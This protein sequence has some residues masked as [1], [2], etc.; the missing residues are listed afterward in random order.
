MIKTS[1][2]V[3]ASQHE[4]YGMFTVLSILLAPVAFILGIV[5]L[6]KKDILDRKLGEHL[7]AFSVFVM[8]VSSIL[9]YLFVPHQIITTVPT[10]TTPAVMSEPSLPAWDFEGVY[11]RIIEGQT[12]AEVSTIAGRS[13]DSCGESAIGG[14]VYES[15]SYGG[16][17][18]GGII[19]V[20]YV[21]GVVTS[22]SKASI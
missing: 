3:K 14:S 17:S 5:Y 2:R 13:T 4:S 20:N 22:K 15:C 7:I 11:S 9:W 16:V 6:T 8:I 12:K 19:Q 1:N 10:Y 18:D 21:N